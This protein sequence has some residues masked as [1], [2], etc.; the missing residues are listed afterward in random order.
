MPKGIH[1]D[2]FQF[3]AICFIAS[4]NINVVVTQIFDQ[5]NFIPLILI[6]KLTEMSLFLHLNKYLN[7][8]LVRNII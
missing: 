3:I 4:K 1:Q 7:L 5:Y 8:F 2:G 6:L